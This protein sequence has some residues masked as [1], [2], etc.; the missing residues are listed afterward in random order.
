M[1]AYHYVHPARGRIPLG[2]H[3]LRRVDISRR[4]VVSLIC[5]AKGQRTSCVGHHDVVIG[6]RRATCSLG[7]EVGEARHVRG[8]RAL[9]HLQV[10]E[11]CI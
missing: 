11:L 10:K 7:V 5:F 8:T 1:S 4:K 9:S 6:G 2:R 3:I